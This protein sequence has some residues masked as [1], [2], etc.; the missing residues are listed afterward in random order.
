MKYVCQICGHI[1]DPEIGDADLGIAPGTAWEDVPD[2]YICPICG[3]GKDQFEP[4]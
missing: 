3:V 4:A 2:D 1:Y